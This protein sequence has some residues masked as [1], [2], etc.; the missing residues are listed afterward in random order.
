MKNEKINIFFR[1]AQNNLNKAYFM[2][3][4]KKKVFTGFKSFN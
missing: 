1:S 2:K 4:G 3:M